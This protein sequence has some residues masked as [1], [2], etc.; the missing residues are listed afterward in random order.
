MS[1]EMTGAEA[2]V[3]TMQ[4]AGVDTW[5]ANPGT[6]EMHAVAALDRVPGVRCVLGLFENVVTGA[7]DGY[8]RMAGKPAA[9]LL[10]LG[11]GLA[12]GLANLHNARQAASPIVNVVG[13]HASYHRQYDSPLK[14]DVEGIAR[15]LSHWLKT[16]AG[17]G[18]IGA[19]SAEAVA[20][21]R[22]GSGRIATL[23]LPADTSWSNGGTVETPIA[24]PPRARVS[25]NAIAA[26]AAVLRRGGPHIALMIGGAALRGIAPELGGRI[27]AKT[28]CRLLSPFANAR[29]E[30]GAGRVV[31][32]RLP[33]VVEPAM[34][35]LADLTDLVL[36]GAPIP[37]AFFAYPGRASLLAPESCTI[38]E[39]AGVDD[40][41]TDTLRRLVDALDAGH[42][43]PKRYAPKAPAGGTSML[44][45]VGAAI[46][47]NFPE[48]AVVIDESITSGP[49][50]FAGTVGAPPHDWLQNMGGSIGLGLPLATGAALAC[51]D[52][53]TI[54]FES[55]GSGMYAPQALWTQ[56]RENLDITTVVFANRAYAVLRRE[57]IK[58][59]AG[60]PGRTAL[61][62]IELDRPP[63]DWTGLARSMGV[64]AARVTDPA[65]FAGTWAKALATPGPSLIELVT[66]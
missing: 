46:G 57:L 34:E 39:I 40:D 52:R 6:S 53:K 29:V 26:A 21:A 37:V 11:P 65:D 16:S 3:R 38:H 44:E 17:V 12:N 50:I 56:A 51:P 18:D 15:P 30:R 55:D 23:I 60:N 61:D 45:Q 25:D 4:A 13:D 8:A 49:P 31:V 64:D 9:T 2:M 20:A 22:T 5:F 41:L 54:C 7:A 62:M 58:V 27:A 36:V 1:N 10:H 43:E 48:N 66:G 14:S 59:R 35:R 63:I 47:A 24:P 28:G 33:S 32:E 42:A 19:D